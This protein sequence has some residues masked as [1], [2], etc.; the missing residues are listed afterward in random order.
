M[1]RTELKQIVIDQ[2]K[3]PVK[4]E[5]IDRD[6][7][8]LAEEYSR[9]SFIVIISGVRRSGKSTLLYQ[10]RKHSLGYYLNFDDDRLN[11]FRLEDFQL[12][13][14]IFI[15]LY[16]EKEHFYFDEIQ[17]IPEWERFVRRL[18]DLKKKVFVTGSNASMLSRE[19]GTR[20]TGRHLNLVLFPFSFNEFLKFKNI[21]SGNRISTTEQK[22]LL[23]RAFNEYLIKGGMPEYLKTDNAEYLKLMYDNILYRD[24]IVRYHLPNE[25]A[26]KDIVNLAANSIAKEISFNSLKKAAGLGSSTTVKDYFDYLENSFLIFLAPRFDYSL[27]KQMYANK[28]VYLIDSALAVHLGY[29][30][31]KDSGRLL[32]NV[33]FLELKRRKKEIYYSADK[34]ECDFVIKEGIKIAEAIQ[35]CYE[36]TN[37]NKQRELEG[38]EEAMSKFKLKEG[39]ILTKSQEDS[40]EIKG[41]KIKVKPVWSWLLGR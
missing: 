28:K 3:Q 24:I 33:V 31:S 11:K 20:L 25:R 35:V 23:L 6:I 5:L 17:N 34:R 22:A 39:L 1:E 15:E 4:D 16:G 29:R 10:L 9:T 37:E 14:E 12:L 26:L 38:L 32:E 7:F 36:L 2:N 27:R 41:R 8:K 13:Y 19:L 30:T 18:H 40:F 21:N